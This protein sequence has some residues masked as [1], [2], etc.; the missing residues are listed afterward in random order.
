MHADAS[1]PCAHYWH[2]LTLLA[3]LAIDF[4]LVSGGAI[5]GNT[6]VNSGQTRA[7][8]GQA[9]AQE[10]TQPVLL[11]QCTDIIVKDNRQ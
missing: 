1:G 3:I 9:T 5:S 8:T 10:D 7:F 2:W 11:K 4:R 6:F